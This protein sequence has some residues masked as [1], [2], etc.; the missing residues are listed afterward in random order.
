MPGC[1]PGIPSSSDKHGAWVETNARHVQPLGIA[2][3][4]GFLQAANRNRLLANINVK[5]RQLGA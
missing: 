3:V 5:Q 2:D 4:H 1:I